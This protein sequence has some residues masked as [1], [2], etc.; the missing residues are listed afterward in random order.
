MLSLWFPTAGSVVPRGDFFAILLLPLLLCTTFTSTEA[1][2]AL[3]PTGNI[4]IKWDVI[5]WTPDGYIYKSFLACT[6]CCYNVQFS[7][8]S[9]YSGSWMDTRVD[10]G[11]KGRDCSRFKGNIPHCCKKDPTVVDLLPGTP[12]NQ[13]IANCCSG[14]VLTSWAQDPQNAISSFQLSVGLAGTTNE[15]VKLPKKFTLKAPGPVTWNVTCTY[16]QF[17]AQK[18]PTCRVSLILL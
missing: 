3:D 9:P 18:T 4:T 12:Y 14:G 10:M 2:D 7:T 5:S 17:L 6:G 11:K 15:T 1:H 16:S 8:V 13:Q